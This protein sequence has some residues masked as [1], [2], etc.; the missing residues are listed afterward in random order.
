V[1]EYLPRELLTRAP[2]A[3]IPVL[4]SFPD[5]MPDDQ[6]LS[7]VLRLYVDEFGVVRRVK[8]DSSGS[9]ESA[10]A[11][12]EQA[13]RQARFNPGEVNGHPVKSIIDV[14]VTFDSTSLDTAH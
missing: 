14:E 11:M 9:L 2:S 1:D 12:A 7:I 10:L 4:L 13:F 6:I 5:D 8:R 3:S